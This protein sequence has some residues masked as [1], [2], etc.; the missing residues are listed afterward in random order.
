MQL[1]TKKLIDEYLND[2]TINTFMN[3]ISQGNDEELTCQRWLRSSIPKRFLF[4]LLYDDLLKPDAS[5]QSILDVGGGIT[6]FS[7]EL[8]KL[9]EYDL[10]DL[11]AHDN[12]LICKKMNSDVRRDFIYPM[13]WLSFDGGDYDLIIANDLFPN[14]DQRL[15]MFLDHF[16]PKCK[17]IR[18]SLT[19]Y[20][21]PRAYKVRSFDSEEIFFMLA[22]NLKQLMNVLKRYANHIVDYDNECFKADQKSLYANGRQVG[23]IELKGSIK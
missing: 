16:L 8:A 1:I 6:C 12:E 20:D 19:W 4:K 13:D 18:L 9:H 23:V 3:K 7:R 15:E 10:V 2:D 22:W 21:S 17:I 11:L 5:H 14:V